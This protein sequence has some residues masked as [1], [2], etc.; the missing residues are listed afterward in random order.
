[1]R[2][3]ACIY[4]GLVLAGC[5]ASDGA[6]VIYDG[7]MVGMVRELSA[8]GATYRAR[9]A[10]DDAKC[11]RLGF[12]PGT[13]GYGNCRLKL[14]QIRATHEAADTVAAAQRNQ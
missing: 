1:M 7:T 12:K 5:T 6:P 3:V 9:Q 14:D 2:T 11:Q 8:P 10:A 13:E 4:A